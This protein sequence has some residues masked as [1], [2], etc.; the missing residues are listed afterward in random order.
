MTTARPALLMFN[1]NEPEGVG[2]TVRQLEDVC[3]EI[4]IVDSSTTDAYERLREHL[5][6]SRARI[7]RVLPLGGPEILRA[8]ADQMV[9][10]RWVLCV[11]ADEVVTEPL[12]RRVRSVPE[13]PPAYLVPRYERSLRTVTWHPR[14]YQRGRLRYEGW[15]HAGP[16]VDGPAV[17][18]RPEERL[19][20][21]ADYA[22]YLAK[23]N[24]LGSYLVAE[25]YERPFTG[26]SL[27]REFPGPWLRRLLPDSPE[28]LSPARAWAFL[29]A[30]R[31]GQWLPSSRPLRRRRH[32]RYFGAYL[33][34]RYRAFRA[35]SDDDRVEASRIAEEL[36]RVG[37]PAA[38]LGLE[39]VEKLRRLT[40]SAPWDVPGGEVLRTLLRTRH[41]TGVSP[42][43][44]SLTMETLRGDPL[45]GSAGGPG[46][47]P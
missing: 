19:D 39:S 33:K 38:Y 13:G 20:H 42:D 32:R 4:V 35:L 29:A 43:D 37:G 44:G 9:R 18:L 47:R 3:E 26:R 25:S 8:F 1:R 30:W 17:P 11:D 23:E 24:R 12:A 28:P 7:E 31:F 27:R 10:S 21:E 36:R 34:A 2:R 15:I 40:R 14:L 45:L 16:T 46:A 22:R 6:A 41:R 5:R